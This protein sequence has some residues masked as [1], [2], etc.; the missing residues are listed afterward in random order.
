MYILKI[1]GG[2]VPPLP[3]RA[4]AHGLKLVCCLL[5]RCYFFKDAENT[6]LELL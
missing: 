6:Q 1:Q 4:G 2:Q 3:Q 5:L